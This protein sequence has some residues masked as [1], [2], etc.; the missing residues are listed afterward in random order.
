[1]TLILSIN[2]AFFDGLVYRKIVPVRN[3]I[4]SSINID[5]IMIIIIVILQ[6]AVAEVS[7][8]GNLQER[9]VFAMHGLQGEPTDRPK[10]VKKIGRSGHRRAGQV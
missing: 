2:F 8:V 7:N 5:T 9:S 3:D 1:M 6:K 10:D 4:N